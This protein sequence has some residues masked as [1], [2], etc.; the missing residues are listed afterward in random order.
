MDPDSNTP[1]LTPLTTVEVNLSLIRHNLGEIRRLIGPGPRIMAVIKADAYGH[2]AIPVART[3]LESGATFLAVARISEAVEL[4][5]AGIQAPLLLLGEVHA[6]QVPYLCHHDIRATVLSLDTARMLSREA[7]KQPRPLKVHIKIDTGMGRLGFLHHSG[8]A[9]PL[10]MDTME[11]IHTIHG[12]EGLK[13]EGIYTHFANADSQDKGHA[14]EQFTLFSRLLDRLEA[15]GIRP[16]LCHAANS[17]AILEMPDTHLD[18]VRAGIAMYG[19]WPSNAVD[20]TRA[21]LKPAMSIISRIIHLKEIP[22]GVGV[23][24]GSTFKS[25][26]K[27]RIATVPIGY[28]DGYKRSLSSRGH[29]IVRGKRVPI[30]GRICMDFTMLDVGQVPQ[31]QPGDEVILLGCQGKSR[32]SAEEIADICDTINYEIV[33]SLT[34][35]MPIRYVR[36]QEEKPSQP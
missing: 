23:S 33:A 13:V 3:V 29:M 18:M 31:A 10:S 5:T 35:R 17:A 28:A 22:S 2:G 21:D 14:R 26:R 19:L 30:A 25:S 7:V 9:G 16:A 24:Y 34:R 1:Q 36:D 6:E 20:H 27:T 32:V 15:R 4:R 12:L 11:S 8:T